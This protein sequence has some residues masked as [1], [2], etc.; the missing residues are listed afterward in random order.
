MRNMSFSVK[1]VFIIIVLGSMHIEKD[2]KINLD[3][4]DKNVIWKSEG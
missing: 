3:R 4:I 1:L 2:F